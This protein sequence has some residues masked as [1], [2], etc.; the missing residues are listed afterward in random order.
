MI[1]F[2]P[3]LFRTRR[4]TSMPPLIRVKR[5]RIAISFPRDGL[6]GAIAAW[7]LVLIVAAGALVIVPA[8]HHDS[9]VSSP[10]V[11]VRVIAAGAAA[12]QRQVTTWGEEDGSESPAS[13]V[14][15]HQGRDPDEC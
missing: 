3:T 5:W 9:G 1:D 10:L 11:G 6:G 14:R 8:L 7:M 12:P 4:E 2:S 15:A 13:L